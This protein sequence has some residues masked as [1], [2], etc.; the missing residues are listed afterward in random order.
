VADKL[1][2]IIVEAFGRAMAE[3]A[4]LPLHGGKASSPLFPSSSAGKEAAQRCKDDGLLR[5]VRTE[6]RGKTA[7]EICALTEKGLAYLLTELSPKRVLED[8]VRVLEARRGQIDA[9]VASAQETQAGFDALK[10]IAQ[11]VLDQVGRSSTSASPL[12]PDKNKAATNGSEAWLTAALSHLQGKKSAAALEDCP[13]PELYRIACQGAPSLTIGRFHDGMRR[14]HDLQQIYLHP[15]TG[16][17][18]ELPEPKLALLIGH[19]IAYYA[20]LP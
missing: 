2:P 10:T 17:L 6:T 4:G 12:L 13:L 11:R 18:H 19:E 9:L 15:W 5:V 1:T 7:Q 8:L 20:S 14:L 16:P 3:P